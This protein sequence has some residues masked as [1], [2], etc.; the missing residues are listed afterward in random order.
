LTNFL[1]CII[2]IV[3]E[4]ETEGG[5]TILKVTIDREECTS[6]GVCWDDCPDVFEENSDDGFSQIVEKYRTGDDPG[7]GEVGSD[8]EE[9]VKEAADNCPVEI[10]HVE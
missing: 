9:C 6:C 8:L 1:L 3:V 4:K 7:E 2:N 10:I 5:E